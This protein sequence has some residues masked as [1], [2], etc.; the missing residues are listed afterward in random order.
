LLNCT[1]PE[2]KVENWLKYEMLH[3][4]KKEVKIIARKN[5]K[6]VHNTVKLLNEVYN[7]TTPQKKMEADN[8]KDKLQQELIQFQE[9][10]TGFLEADTPNEKEIYRNQIKKK[11]EK[12]SVFTMFKQQI[13]ADYL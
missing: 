2:H 1:Y 13:W 11:L 10:I 7:G 9:M 5:E 3:F 8:I 4:P 6:I 12:S